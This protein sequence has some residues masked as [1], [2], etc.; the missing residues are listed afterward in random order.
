MK[1]SIA[2]LLA[3][4]FCAV[5]AASAQGTSLTQ[6]FDGSSIG[7][8][9]ACDGSPITLDGT[10]TTTTDQ[11]V[12]GAGDTHTR[13]QVTDNNLIFVSGGIS[14]KINFTQKAVEVISDE[15]PV[16]ETLTFR[17]RMIGPGSLNN[18]LFQVDTHFTATEGLGTPPDRFRTSARCT[19]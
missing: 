2:A 8:F 18:M 4:L 11:W 12:D 19:G 16:R 1:T 7:T 5:A 9:S 10:F 14:Y 6:T 15:G 3:F 13:A 17:L